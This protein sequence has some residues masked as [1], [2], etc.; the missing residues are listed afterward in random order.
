MTLFRRGKG[1]VG[2]KAQTRNG[3]L[4][5]IGCG[6]VVYERVVG[7]PVPSEQTFFVRNDVGVAYV[8]EIAV[9]QFGVERGGVGLE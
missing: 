2:S 9:V 7:G 1:D 4:I 3:L 8:Y 5:C 6:A